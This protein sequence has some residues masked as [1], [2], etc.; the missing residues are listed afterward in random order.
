MTAEVAIRFSFNAS[1]T[2]FG[3]ATGTLIVAAPSSP[4]SAD[5]Y[6]FVGLRCA[7]GTAFHPTTRGPNNFM[8]NPMTCHGLRVEVIQPP[9]SSS[10]QCK[11]V[12]CC[13]TNYIYYTYYVYY[14]YYICIIHS[15]ISIYSIYI[16]V[17]CQAILMAQ[18]P[19]VPRI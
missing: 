5:Q 14:I 9:G 12:F 8:S 13:H 18:V 16:Y 10:M 4:F 15:Y 17:L 7:S 19:C 11:R 1:K 3:N 2:Q 6:R